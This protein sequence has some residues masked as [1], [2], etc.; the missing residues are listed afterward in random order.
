MSLNIESLAII[1]PKTV[2][3]YLGETQTFE[4][5]Q[6]REIIIRYLNFASFSDIYLE[7]RISFVEKPCDPSRHS[8]SR[9]NN[10]P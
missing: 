3:A 2:K 6:I 7:D 4:T 1:R 10:H 5:G 8:K 9:V